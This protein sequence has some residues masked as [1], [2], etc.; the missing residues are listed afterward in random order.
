MNERNPYAHRMR[1]AHLN[2]HKPTSVALEPNAPTR[3]A[4]AQDLDLLDLPAMRLEAEISA[5]GSSAWVVEGRLTAKV[6]QPCVATLAPVT[7]QIDEP[8]RRVF[9]PHATM[10]EAE[11]T[12]MPDDEIEP[13]GQFIDLGE[14]AVEALALALP[15][16]PRAEGA[17]LIG[18]EE[19]DD[20]AG[21]TRRPF[22]GLDKLMGAKKE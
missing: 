6:V 15:L 8:V 14:I 3:Q 20:D 7:T 9:S 17:Q 21:E 16:Y 19:T 13:L 18:Q 12:E 10:P 1:V 5:G 2:P 4:I 11:E 22:A